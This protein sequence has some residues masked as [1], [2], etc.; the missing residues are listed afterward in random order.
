MRI[1]YLE[2][3]PKEIQYIIQYHKSKIYSSLEKAVEESRE[4]IIEFLKKELQDI[5]IVFLITSLGG[6]TGTG[7]TP[8]ISSIIRSELNKLVICIATIPFS[9]EGRKRQRTAINTLEK[10]QDNVDILITCSDD[11]SKNGGTVVQM[12]KEVDKKIR[13]IVFEVYEAINTSNIANLDNESLEKIILYKGSY[14]T[15]IGRKK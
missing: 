7:A 6:G 3:F 10:I 12:F 15:F 9:F 2:I 4:E 11:S 5:D 13:D 8:L 14:N 1:Y